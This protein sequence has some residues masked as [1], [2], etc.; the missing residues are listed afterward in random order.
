[1]TQLA[2]AI[3]SQKE[4]PPL[5]FW[6]TVGR[7]LLIPIVLVA[8]TASPI[9]TALALGV[10]I[11]VDL[12]DGVVAR[13]LDADDPARRIL[14]SLV[15]RSAIWMVYGTLASTGLLPW[16]LFAGLLARDFY[17]AWQCQK[18]IRS[19]NVAIRADWPYRG[20]NLML[21]GWVVVAPLLQAQ[22]RIALFSIVLAVS[23]LVAVDLRR[24]VSV[25]LSLPE[26]VNGV[27]LPAG[28]LRRAGRSRGIESL[29]APSGS[30]QSA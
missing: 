11:A 19:R 1:L 4:M 15:D 30:L 13:H 18:I 28:R 29:A 3:R 23:T 24:A 6:M 17:C 9:L 22:A 27:V 16:F 10:F 14:D 21:A 7:L 8:F 12:Y 5:L 2:E 25:V 26:S 20:L